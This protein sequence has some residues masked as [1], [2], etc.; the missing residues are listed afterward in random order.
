MGTGPNEYAQHSS[1]N[2]Y[3]TTLDLRNFKQSKIENMESMFSDSTYTNILLSDTFGNNAIV[4]EN[5]FAGCSNLTS[6]DLR[7]FNTDNFESYYAMCRRLDALT[8][9]IVGDMWDISME[10]AGFDDPESSYK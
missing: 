6:L 8:S 2:P 5:T 9:F 10:E 4:C 1:Y 7:S 3:I